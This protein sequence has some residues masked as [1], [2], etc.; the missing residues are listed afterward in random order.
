M[1]EGDGRQDAT[2][3]DGEKWAGGHG[4]CPAEDAGETP[5]LRGREKKGT[6]GFWVWG[7]ERFCGTELANFLPRNTAAP[8][9]L[10]T[11]GLPPRLVLR[12]PPLGYSRW[13]HGWGS[14]QNIWRQ[15]CYDGARW[16]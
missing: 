9:V 16:K 7:R 14:G 6:Q 8:D 5:V 11:A 2:S 1:G 15:M 3:E 12:L 10:G 4:T 13:I